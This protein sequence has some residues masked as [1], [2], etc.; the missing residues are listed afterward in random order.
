MQDFPCCV[1]LLGGP[2][3]IDS[4]VVEEVQVE[5]KINRVR[6]GWWFC[7]KVDCGEICRV[8]NA[9]LKDVT[10]KNDSFGYDNRAKTRERSYRETVRQTARHVAEHAKL[11]YKNC[12]V[13]RGRRIPTQELR[14]PDVATWRIPDSG[15]F[16]GVTVCCQVQ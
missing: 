14:P 8:V 12:G 10:L 16:R 15:Q 11:C 9:I 3:F 6:G 13:Q 5:E 7:T 1:D 2:T 4:E